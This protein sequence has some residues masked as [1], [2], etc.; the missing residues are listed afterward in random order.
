MKKLMKAA[1]ITFLLA[2]SNLSFSTPGTITGVP[3]EVFYDAGANLIIA[4]FQ[5]TG[6]SY[7]T[8][9]I[10]TVAAIAVDATT[11]EQEQRLILTALYTAGATGK[12]VRLGLPD[13]TSCYAGSVGLI[14]QAGS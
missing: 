13:T 10:A 7:C 2:T 14:Y 1:A 8:Y 4:I 9:G 11:T 6:L 3:A 5:N 12:Q